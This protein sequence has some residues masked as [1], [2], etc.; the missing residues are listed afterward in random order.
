MFIG[1][2]QELIKFNNRYNTN[3]FNMF[4]FSLIHQK[5]PSIHMSIVRKSSKIY[6]S[7]GTFYI[8]VHLVQRSF[9]LLYVEFHEHLS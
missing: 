6:Y 5:R 9:R 1:F 2:E 7:I 3:I 4:T 8:Q